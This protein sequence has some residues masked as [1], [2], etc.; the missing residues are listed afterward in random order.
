[1]SDKNLSEK[2]IV[3]QLYLKTIIGKRCKFLRSTISY[4]EYNKWLNQ[5]AKHLIEL[6]F[7]VKEMSFIV[8]Q[9][10]DKANILVRGNILGNKKKD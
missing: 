1:M 6:G 4:S 10:E 8:Q 3:K 5:M 2:E 7:T 9:A